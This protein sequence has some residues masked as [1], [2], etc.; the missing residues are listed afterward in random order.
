MKNWFVRG[1]RRGLVVVAAFALTVVLAASS[2]EAGTGTSVPTWVPFAAL[3]LLFVG[4]S[5]LRRGL[6]DQRAD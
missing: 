3:A 4:G 1:I 2:S 6:L 5:V